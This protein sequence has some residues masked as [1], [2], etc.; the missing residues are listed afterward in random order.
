MSY[1][2]TSSEL[3]FVNKK[4][5]NNQNFEALDYWQGD[6]KISDDHG[7]VVRNENFDFLY[8]VYFKILCRGVGTFPSYNTERLI[9]DLY[10]GSYVQEKPNEKSI[11]YDTSPEIASTYNDF[12]DFVE[13]WLG[14][15]QEMDFDPDH[16]ENERSLFEK[17]IKRFGPRIGA[18]VYP[19]AP[20]E[21][22]LRGREADN[23]I[24]Q[25][26]DFLLMFP[27]GKSLI[28][29][30]GGTEHDEPVQA[31]RD[32]TRDQAFLNMGI[33]TLRPRNEEIAGND[34]YD[35]IAKELELINA[36]VF[37]KESAGVI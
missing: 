24:G 5:F 27:N 33:Q 28:I 26:V 12:S 16:P 19:Q 21:S 32:R 1:F 11:I 30:P 9:V 34:L 10:G 14:N 29:E 4:G 36:D 22:I 37:L 7:G 15:T 3:S 8:D 20:I 13:P 35:G 2:R 17:L 25:R 23:F 31:A 18:F 6:F